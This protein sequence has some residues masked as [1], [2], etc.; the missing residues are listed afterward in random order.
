M[1]SSIKSKDLMIILS[2]TFV[3]L[4]CDVTIKLQIIIKY[5]ANVLFLGC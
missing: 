2:T 3:C 1:F 5:G 4:S